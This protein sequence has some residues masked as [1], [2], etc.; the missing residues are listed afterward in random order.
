MNAK[1]KFDKDMDEASKD[2]EQKLGELK[3]KLNQ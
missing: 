1:A 3:E 2:L